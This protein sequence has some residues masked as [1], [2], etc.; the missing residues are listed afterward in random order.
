MTGESSTTGKGTEVGWQHW[1]TWSGES[2]A[3]G[4]REDFALAPQAW[5]ESQENSEM[6]RNEVHPEKLWLASAFVVL[7][8]GSK[9]PAIKLSGDCSHQS[10]CQCQGQPRRWWAQQLG[11]KEAS[12]RLLPL[13]LLRGSQGLS[14]LT[15]RPR[16]LSCSL[17]RPH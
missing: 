6:E 3:T 9:T 10:P 8:P 4:S 2:L 12:S 1:P 13:S 15:F 16:F 5:F 17:I 14:D 11:N 7:L